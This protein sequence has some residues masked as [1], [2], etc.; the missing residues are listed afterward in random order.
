M[1]GNLLPRG[2]RSRR[3]SAGNRSGSEGS[4]GAL[5]IRSLEQRAEARN[6]RDENAL[7]PNAD[8][9]SAEQS[10][11]VGALAAFPPESSPR[12][13]GVDQH[14]RPAERN[15]VTNVLAEVTAN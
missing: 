11:V 12:E 5:A 14:G 7:I 10:V 2:C 9:S 3:R 8:L 4:G 1:K 13:A 6:Q 15:C